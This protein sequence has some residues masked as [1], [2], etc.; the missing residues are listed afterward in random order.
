VIHAGRSDLH[1]WGV[2]ARRR[3][4]PGT[5]AERCRIIRV[6]ASQYTYEGYLALGLATLLNHSDDPNC[7]VEFRDGWCTLKSFRRIERG[8]EL[9][10]DYSRR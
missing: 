8:E 10:I 3:I 7:E 2:F 6:D 5:I 4:Y 1:G 9:T